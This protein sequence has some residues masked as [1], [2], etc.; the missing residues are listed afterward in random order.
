MTSG[1]SVMG[2]PGPG[3]V[4][5]IRQNFAQRCAKFG[6]FVKRGVGAGHEQL[7]CGDLSTITWRGLLSW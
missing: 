4:L 3:G 7:G 2:L 1:W 6:W 5:L